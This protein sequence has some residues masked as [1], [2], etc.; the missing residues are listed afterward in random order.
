MSRPSSQVQFPYVPFF[1]HRQV[2]QCCSWATAEGEST[3][4]ACGMKAGSRWKPAFALQLGDPAGLRCLRN[5]ANKTFHTG[6]TVHLCVC[7]LLLSH[8]T[9]RPLSESASVC[10]RPRDI[11][12]SSAM[13]GYCWTPLNIV[14]HTLTATQDSTLEANALIF[15]SPRLVL[16][17][18][19]AQ[20]DPSSTSKPRVCIRISTFPL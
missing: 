18:V 16:L 2:N 5:P 8:L 12:R 9:Q 4:A 15:L 7:A 19:F 14:P 10:G 20:K 11:S 1:S 3:R 13:V 17:F 6:I